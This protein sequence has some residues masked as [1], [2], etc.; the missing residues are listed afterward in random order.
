MNRQD[1]RAG[2]SRR[3]FMVGMAAAA[4]ALGARRWAWAESAPGS[5]I[6]VVH[7]TD[8]ARMLDAGLA[9]FGGWSGCVKPRA[10][11][12]LKPNA[13]WSV[14][15]ETAGNT[16]PALVEHC[17]RECLK[18]GA[19]EV[20]VPENPCSPAKEA[21]ERSG[22]GAAVKRAGG[23]MVAPAKPDQFRRV[24]IPRGV[25]LKEA[26]VACDVLDADCLINMPVAKSHGGAAL[27]LSMKNWMGSVKDRGY[28][29]KNN[30]HQCIA[31]FSTFIKP[32]LI[33][34]DALRI[35]LTK[36][37]RGPGELAEPHELILG[38]DP[39]AVD[40]YAATLFKRQPFDILHIKLAHEMRVGCGDLS[41]V[42]V[43]R[44]EA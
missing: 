4:G 29:H 19:A 28:W 3:Q 13:A 24:S 35:M 34:V 36:G 14:L 8:P 15:P 40:A 26:D 44:I 1:R 9:A 18:A 7:G 41:Q 23:R 2:I 16:T 17:I 21:F 6:V 32:S 42:R 30:L 33:V 38:T 37:P 20:V 12:A 25:S 31:D 22:I 10:R 5:T 39:V 27:T 43:E 11:V